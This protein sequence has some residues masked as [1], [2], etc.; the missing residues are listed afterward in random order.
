MNLKER[1]NAEETKIGAFIHKYVSIIVLAA[2]VAPEILI[3]AGTLPPGTVPQG[4]WTAGLVLGAIAKIGGKL[5]V[6]Q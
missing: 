4:F 5:T 2:G 1:W 3:W 6:K